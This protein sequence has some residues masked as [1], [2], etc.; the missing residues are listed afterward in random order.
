MK[1]NKYLIINILISIIIAMVNTVLTY[2]HIDFYQKI[3]LPKIVLPIILLPLIWVILSILI[4]I[5]SYLIYC[6]QNK[7]QESA[8]ILYYFILL[9]NFIWPITFFNYQNFLLSLAVLLSIFI[10]LIILSYLYYQIKHTSAYLL[11]PYFIW[12]IYNLY[13]N[14][15]I[16]INN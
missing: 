7:Y 6:R 5:S 3:N 8:L 12:I 14:F 4:T 11:I 15:L 10:S 13:F 2:Q 1:K 16:F 9:L